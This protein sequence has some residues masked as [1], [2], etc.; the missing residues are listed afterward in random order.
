MKR[1]MRP[2]LNRLSKQPKLLAAVGG[3]DCFIIIGDD[4]STVPVRHDNS[5]RSHT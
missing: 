3:P 1:I 4:H 5:G 2:V